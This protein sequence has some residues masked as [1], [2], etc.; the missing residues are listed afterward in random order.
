[1]NWDKKSRIEQYICTM[2]NPIF[3]EYFD[4]KKSEIKSWVNS[5]RHLY[6]DDL[7][8]S[9]LS[10]RSK[11]WLRGYIDG[12]F[13]GVDLSDETVNDDIIKELSQYKLDTEIS[14]YRGMHFNIMD[15]ELLQDLGLIQDGTKDFPFPFKSAFPSSWTWNY[16][17]AEDF[18][19]LG[20]FNYII[21]RKF[22]PEEILVDLRLIP[23]YCKYRSIKNNVD[24]IIG[25]LQDEVILKPGNYRC[26]IMKEHIPNDM[27]HL[28]KKEN[29]E[30]LRSFKIFLE[31]NKHNFMDKYREFIIPSIFETE[32]YGSRQGGLES[33][34]FSK[35][36]SFCYKI[37]YDK[38]KY[39]LKYIFITKVSSDS[40][41]IRI[42][43][44][45]YKDLITY[46]KPHRKVNKI[47]PCE[48][49][50]YLKTDCDGCDGKYIMD[51][52]V[53][54]YHNEIVKDNLQDIIDECIWFIKLLYKI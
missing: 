32:H 19:K 51:K 41:N 5:N 33:C 12:I 13:V 7:K 40:E 21:Q 44:R 2:T 52:R 39:S 15:I 23:E 16:K 49:L 27:V 18:A 45:I 47:Y 28:L 26:N 36:V 6:K 38:G 50:S 10:Q 30:A 34:F 22:K 3:S 35:Q 46:N 1:M 48:D 11:Q 9:T 24:S 20:T 42:M 8:S 4:E 53:V 29:Y 14:L 17:V 31:K 37:N 54:N 43:R 25:A